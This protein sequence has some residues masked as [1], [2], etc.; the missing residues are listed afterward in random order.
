MRIS[1]RL[2]LAILLAGLLLVCALLSCVSGP[3][4]CQD[5]DD[6]PSNWSCISRRC[7]APMG[8]P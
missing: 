6:C 7:E 4:P 5:D 3:D 2:L 1:W 8:K